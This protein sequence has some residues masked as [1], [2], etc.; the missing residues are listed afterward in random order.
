[1]AK[2]L[3]L[4]QAP[5]TAASIKIAAACLRSGG[6]AILPTDTI[7]GL[8]CRADKAAAIRKIKKLKGNEA[9]KPLL[10]LV[11]SL[12][13]LKKYTFISRSQSL[14][15]NKH[16]VRGTRP[17]TVILP[18]RG[19]LPKELTGDSDGLA[20]RLPKS[21]FLIKILRVIGC[22]LVSTS[23]NHSGQ[24]SVRNLKRLTVDFPRAAKEADLIVDAG[25]CRRRKVSRL[26][27]LRT[28]GQPILIRK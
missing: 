26:L 18:H 23:L 15:L 9:K 7:Y 10:I 25:A 28:E 22:P 17:T 3:S 2:T 12:A 13:M 11:D 5:D 14:W 19:L 24:E 6:I 20:A 1:M 27:D 16:W 21:E 4:K 8:S